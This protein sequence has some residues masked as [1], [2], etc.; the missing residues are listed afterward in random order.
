MQYTF[1][2]LLKVCKVLKKFTEA[3]TRKMDTNFAGENPHFNFYAGQLTRDNVFQ[4]SRYAKDIHAL[5]MM[6]VALIFPRVDEIGTAY[7]G[8]LKKY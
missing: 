6:R 7:W 5:K 4:K 1:H 8:K 2:D 3:N